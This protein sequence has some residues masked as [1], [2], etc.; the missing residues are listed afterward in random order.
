MYFFIVNNNKIC[1]NKKE[2]RRKERN[3][4]MEKIHNN[5]N[6]EN[7]IKTDWFNQFDEYQKTGILIG[8]ED[9]L[10]VSIYAKP[11]F[12]WEQMNQIILGLKQELN[13]FIYAKPEYNWEQMRKI[14]L[15]LLKESTL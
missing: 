11:D 1:Y 7:L 6:I 15:K 12:N 9:N 5:L 13:V 14:R 10:D 4:K 3:Y 8:L 2:N